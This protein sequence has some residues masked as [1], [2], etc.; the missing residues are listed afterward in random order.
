[1]SGYYIFCDESIKKGKHYSNFYG[2]L[3]IEKSQFERV[4]NALI[5][6]VQDLEIENSELKWSNVNNYQLE[7][8]KQLMDTFFAFV[9][10]GVIKVR[11][12]FTDN[13]FIVHDLQKE[14]HDNQYH[15]LYYTFIKHAFG[16]QYI[17]SDIPLDIEIFFDKLPD[18]EEKNERFKYFIHGIP[19]L[20]PFADTGI[21]I[22]KESLYEVDSKKHI[23][24]QCIDVVLGSMAFRLN[25]L[26][27]VIPEGK[28][29]RGKRTVA[30]ENLY[31]HIY[32]RL[33]EIRPNFNIGISTG[34]DGEY[35]N[36][37]FQ[38]Y[39]HWLFIPKT[40]NKTYLD[41]HK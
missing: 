27:K 21:L 36:R 13:R 38:K 41:T 6:K 10:E 33:A 3:I 34:V 32:K 26:H 9:L 28:K 23:L 19:Y 5:S 25:D 18:K 8:Y 30:K 22:K 29:R 2:G 4:N 37:F 35:N 11:I 1:M 39:R 24:M 31:K 15:I 20:P 7:N 40:K 17:I 12:M 14:H 16:L